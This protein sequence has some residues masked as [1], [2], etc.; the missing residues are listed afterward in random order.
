MPLKMAVPKHN[1]IM[2]ITE[3]YNDANSNIINQTSKQELLNILV[4]DSDPIW[5]KTLKLMLEDAYNCKIQQALNLE[6]ITNNLEQN[7]D[8]V[9]MDV[10]S[11]DGD[12]LKFAKNLK[13]KM[14]NTPIIVITACSSDDQRE[15]INETNITDII[16]KPVGYHSL[17]DIIDYYVFQSDIKP[18]KLG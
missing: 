15:V 16:A 17:I 3:T 2:D 7:Y 9:I 12:F 13:S 11:P 18:S 4:L 8:L 6:Q 1:I 5:Q 14:K 10:G